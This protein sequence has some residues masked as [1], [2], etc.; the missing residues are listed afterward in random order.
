MIRYFWP[1]LREDRR[2]LWITLLLLVI[3]GTFPAILGLVPVLLTSNY[4]RGDALGS[5]W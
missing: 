1:F 3:M 2:R 4:M 5:G